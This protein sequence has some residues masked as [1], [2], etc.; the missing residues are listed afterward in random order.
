MVGG[1][2]KEEGSR[3]RELERSG[4]REGGREAAWPKWLPSPT[5]M[6][7]A[8]SMRVRLGLGF[9]HFISFEMR[10]VGDCLSD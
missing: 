10:L 4:E 5:V 6:N 2:R 3:A 1:G 7:I 9:M 8:I